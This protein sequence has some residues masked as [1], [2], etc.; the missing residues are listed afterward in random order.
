MWKPRYLA[1][2]PCLKLLSVLPLPPITRRIL[3][4]VPPRMVSLSPEWRSL[5]GNPVFTEANRNSGSWGSVFGHCLSQFDLT[6]G[7]FCH[8]SVTEVGFWM[9][10]LLHY[11]GACR[12]DVASSDAFQ[13]MA[14]R[15]HIQL[16]H[17][18]YLLH[19][20]R[21]HATERYNMW[22]FFLFLPLNWDHFPHSHF[23][24]RLVLSQFGVPPS[25]PCELVWE[26]PGEGFLAFDY[27]LFFSFLY[28]FFILRTVRN[29]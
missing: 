20:L 15:R 21:T 10:R 8:R 13:G 26:R 17:I 6:F 29:G 9:S 23:I 27:S 19:L 2:S 7:C 25:L 11:S 3:F 4:A 12:K 22:P 1:S 28:F 18:P 14:L 24:T 16:E 5:T